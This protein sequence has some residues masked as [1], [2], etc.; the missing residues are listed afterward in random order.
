MRR[1]ALAAALLCAAAAGEAHAAFSPP[2]Q[3][4]GGA[5]RLAV[6]AASDAAGTTTA[7]VTGA[8]SPK[9]LARRRGGTWAPAVR[10]PGS[11]RGVAGPVLDAA[12]D[13]ALAIAWRVDAPRRYSGVDVALRDPGG[14]LSEPIAVAGAS[15]GGVRHPAIAVDGAGDALLAYNSAT[16]ASHLSLRG[17]IAVAYRLGGGG[18]VSRPVIVDRQL[19]GPPAVALAPDGTGVVAWA[20][21]GRLYTATVLAGGRIARPLALAK[22]PGLRGLAAVAGA[23]AATVAWSGRDGVHAATR[24]AGGEFGTPRTLSSVIAFVPDLALAVDERGRATLAWTEE[25]SRGDRV[26]TAAASVGHAFG[27]PRTL[28]TSASRRFG[29]PAVGAARGRA[30]IAWSYTLG[31][32]RHGVQ[33]VAGTGAPQTLAATTLTNAFVSEAPALAVAADPRG[34]ATVLFGQPVPTPTVLQWRLLAADG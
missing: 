24:T 4:I 29:P 3:L 23:D 14:A 27:A 12:G 13:G 6:T 15:A 21:G 32:S 18:R 16:R 1:A 19:S 11:P 10:L 2:T 17:R 9:L 30:V 31:R 20:R 8:G 33:A 25:R 26:L 7:V 22:A 34:P 28:A 5:T